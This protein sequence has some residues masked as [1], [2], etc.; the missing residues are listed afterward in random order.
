MLNQYTRYATALL[1]LTHTGLIRADLTADLTQAVKATQTDLSFRGHY[2]DV[3]SD[4]QSNASGATLRSV[5]RIESGEIQHSQ[6]TLELENITTITN[7]NFSNGV[8]N[9]G[10]A[11]I[12]D[13]DITEINQAYFRF[14]GIPRSI[15][16][17]GRQQI[18]LDNHRFVGDV[19]FRQNQQTYDAISL[20][21]KPIS[22]VSVYYAHLRAVNTILGRRATNG[23]QH[24][25]SDL[26]NVQYQFNERIDAS[27][28][29]YRLQN[30]DLPGSDHN[31]TGLRFSGAWPVD[32]FALG[33]NLDVARQSTT[34]SAQPNA[35]M[36]Y[37]STELSVKR[38]RYQLIW[39]NESLGSD[40]N[41]AFQTPL[42][43]LHKFQGFTDQF[44]VTPADGL[45]DEYITFRI[46]LGPGRIE[47]TAHDFESDH[48]NR[49]LGTEH[50]LGAWYRI[51][52]RGKVL[53]KWARFDGARHTGD[54]RKYWLQLAYDI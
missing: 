39:G 28:Y 16:Q 9:K 27:A 38:G 52:Q 17:I 43:T 5:L 23:K 51:G 32:K 30:E 12:A 15:L 7:K 19:G 20:L 11:V 36:N 50:S 40:N 42:A 46:N 47:L 6:F 41:V 35:D 4:L 24:H 49:T 25:D 33:V 22:K 8:R 13:P 54:I 37:R 53:V 3:N 45:E 26:L 48:N 34:G 2:E 21:S 44:L 10:T 14:N 1:L 18:T 31:T 29:H